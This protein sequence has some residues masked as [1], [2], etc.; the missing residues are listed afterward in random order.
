MNYFAPM[1]YNTQQE[2]YYVYIIRCND[3]SYYTGLTDDLVRR[4]EEHV[5]GIYEN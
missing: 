3:G 2:V 1:L 5:T 4:F